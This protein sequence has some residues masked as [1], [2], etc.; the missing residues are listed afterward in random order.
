MTEVDIDVMPKVVWDLYKE[1]LDLTEVAP[2]VNRSGFGK[3]TL[4]HQSDRVRVLVFF[5]N[6]GWKWNWKDSTLFIDGEKVQIATS[7]EHYASIFKNPDRGRYEHTPDGAKKANLPVMRILDDEQVK[8][9]PTAVSQS[10]RDIKSRVN[11]DETCVNLHISEESNAYIITLENARK[12]SVYAKFEIVGG[13][14][15]PSD[16]TMVNPLGYDVSDTYEGASGRI[17]A[18]ILGDMSRESQRSYTNPGKTQ[19]QA[20][21]SNSVSVK[22]ATV[23]RV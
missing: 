18:D 22:K 9:A 3:I 6:P 12:L 5:H 23:F 1:I 14:W 7:P 20:G 4:S 10:F 21:M 11:D 19:G 8:H 17:I 15:A 13:K 16:V 2:T